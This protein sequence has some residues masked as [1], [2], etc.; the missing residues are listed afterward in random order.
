MGRASDITGRLAAW[1]RGEDSALDGPYV[2]RLRGLAQGG[3]QDWNVTGLEG[4]VHPRK[5]AAGR[6]TG[7]TGVAL[8]RW[9]ALAA[10]APA[11]AALPPKPGDRWRFNAF[12][13]ER[14]GGLRRGCDCGSSVARLGRRSSG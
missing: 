8:L 5:D 13:I 2:H 12:R 4:R 3:G 6:P 10:K 14:Q 11:G 1:S 7:W 9:T